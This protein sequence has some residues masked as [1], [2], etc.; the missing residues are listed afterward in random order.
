MGGV[1]QSAAI[2]AL[3]ACHVSPWTPGMP[4]P[5]S[6][7][8]VQALVRGADLR[9]LDALRA[10]ARSTDPAVR[11]AA[12]LGMAQLG[13]GR[14]VD[15]AQGAIGERDA[16]VRA[17]AAEVF[18]LL[19][20]TTAGHGDVRYRAVQA[21]VEDEVTAP[22]G[23]RLAE[24][25]QDGGVAPARRPIGLCVARSCTRSAAARCPSRSPRCSR[26]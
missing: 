14:A 17:A 26:S 5:T 4:P 9:S 22:A 11:A 20:A 3:I 23:V 16:R 15:L 19:D 12:L 21:L 10:S 25:A 7:A 24:R 6:A 18:V 1:G 2:N 8:S 13:D